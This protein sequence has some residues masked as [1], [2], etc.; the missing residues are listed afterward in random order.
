MFLASSARLIERLGG[1]GVP[2]LRG[3]NTVS[4]SS[5]TDVMDRLMETDRSFL[6]HAVLQ[7]VDRN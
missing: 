6:I 5:G 1:P 2:A 7:C 3:L 4:F